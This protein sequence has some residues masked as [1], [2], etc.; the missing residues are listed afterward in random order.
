MWGGTTEAEIVERKARAV[1]ALSATRA[2]MS[3]GIVPGAG[4]AFLRIAEKVSATRAAGDARFGVEVVVNALMA[5]TVQLANNAGF[6]G[7]AV[8]SEILEYEDFEMG[9]DA[10][11]GKVADLLSRGVID[12]TKVLRVALQNAAS[13]AALYLTSD[14]TITDLEKDE[15]AVQGALV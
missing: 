10:K 3:E 4:T 7:P 15:D 12:P 14:T 6:D 13:V 11:N 1:D 8:V 9:F 5:P 2:A